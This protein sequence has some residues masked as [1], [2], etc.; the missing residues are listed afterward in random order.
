MDVERRQIGIGVTQLILALCAIAAAIGA[1]YFA[2]AYN[3]NDAYAYSGGAC[4]LGLL[5][6][7]VTLSACVLEIAKS[8]RRK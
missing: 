5:S 6:G 7:L 3:G 4:G 8:R 2:T 1:I